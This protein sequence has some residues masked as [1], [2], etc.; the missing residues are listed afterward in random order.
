MDLG[1]FAQIEDLGEVARKNGIVV[2]RER[3]YRYMKEESPIPEE[4]I[5]AAAER[6][7]LK[8]CEDV[9][10]QCGPSTYEYS[11]RTDRRIKKYLIRKTITD[12][13]GFQYKTTVAVKW[14]V[15]HGKLRK[16]MKFASKKAKAKKRAQLEMFN[17][18]VGRE[19]VLYIRS[20]IGGGNWDYFGGPALAKEQW[21][22]DKIDDAYDETY[23]DI[24]AKIDPNTIKN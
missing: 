14:N 9:L 6:H 23:C 21:F 20:R 1:A 11:S 2:P 10:R 15:V 18:Y 4:A 5:Q 8:E 17:K 13:D 3:G 16:A 19:D 22:L 7:A 24:Y 12:P